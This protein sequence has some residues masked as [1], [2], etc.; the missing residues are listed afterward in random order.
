MVSMDGFRW[1]YYGNTSTPNLD[2][3]NERGVQAH[4]LINAF[5]T[6]TFPNHWTLVTGAWQETHGIVSNEMWDPNLGERF[7]M[8]TTKSDFFQ[9][10][11]PVWGTTSRLGIK[12][13]CINWVGC[14]KV[15]QG[16]R[17]TYFEE[18]DH[19]GHQYG[20]GAEETLAAVRRVD[21][22]I[23]V[24]KSRMSEIQGEVNVILTSDH[25]MAW[26]TN[27]GTNLA[28]GVD[29]NIVNITTTGPV[30]HIWPHDARQAESI[31]ASL[32]EAGAGHMTCYLR[33][34]VLDRW[35][36]KANDRIPP[37]VCV[38]DEG[39]QTY[40]GDQFHGLGDHGY[41]NRL[42]DMWPVFIAAGPQI[43]R[44][45]WVQHPFDSV[46]VFA[47][48]A[49]AL[50]IPQS[51]WPPNNASLAE[52]EKQIG[53]AKM[54]RGY[55]NYVRHVR[56]CDRNPRDPSHPSTPRVDGTDSKR[57][58]EGRLRI[59]KQALHKWDTRDGQPPAQHEAST[60]SQSQASETG[61]VATGGVDK[62]SGTTGVGTGDGERE[63]GHG[64]ATGT[65]AMAGGHPTGAG[66]GAVVSGRT[67]RGGTPGEGAGATHKSIGRAERRRMKRG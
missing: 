11:E 55:Q 59:W 61:S 30:A 19:S 43:K 52:R 51:E 12:S 26:A 6:V 29:P 23:G 60:S 13:V 41:D 42:S 62:P 67:A 45:P 22:A 17:P 37:V 66:H 56:K 31:R 7:F 21:R 32:E 38:C 5:T 63:A 28:D 40:L 65:A 57:A 4:H 16:L 44:S 46:H 1:D 36:Y 3:F 53:I 27:P 18:P 39:W 47:I 8:N 58:F 24:L 48:I 20:P 10:A 9:E 14:D 64:L 2:Y 15:V 49:T 50:G 25:G 54:T 34:D 33:Q 35:H